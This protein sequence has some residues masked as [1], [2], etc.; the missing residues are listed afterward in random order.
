[1]IDKLSAADEPAERLAEQVAALYRWTD[2]ME[3]A[4]YEAAIAGIEHPEKLK[5]TELIEKRKSLLK[6]ARTA[7][8]DRLKAAADKRMDGLKRWLQ[9]ERL[10]LEIKLERDLPQGCRGLLGAAWTRPSRRQTC[11]RNPTDQ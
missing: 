7:I 8:A 1:M 4:R 3:Q 11:R 9:I 5:R 6:E 2:R 10:T